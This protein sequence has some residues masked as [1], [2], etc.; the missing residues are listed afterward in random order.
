VNDEKK[1]PIKVVDRRLFRPDGT[2]RSEAA[3]T[4][5][6]EAESAKPASTKE[7][8][9]APAT[10]K[11]TDPRFME[12]AESLAVQALMALGQI[13]DPVTGG[14]PQPNP[15]MASRMVAYLEAIR[16]K[17]EAG[18]SEEEKAWFSETLG[19]LQVALYQ[20]QGERH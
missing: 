2:R 13:Q 7:D 15:A 20:A 3:F 1:K 19:K 9:G 11:P 12:L 8:R 6:K 4:E 16:D 10:G 14:Y 17:A 5:R 18:L